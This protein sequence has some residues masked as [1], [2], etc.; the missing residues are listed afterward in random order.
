MS[1][2]RWVLAGGLLCGAGGCQPDAAPVTPPART[3]AV[4]AASL[5][6]AGASAPED[7][8]GAAAAPPRSPAA[9]EA[10]SVPASAAGGAY[11]ETTFDDLK[12]DMEIGAEFD[13][14][15]LTP[16]V[17][18][19]FGQKIRIRG[20]ILPTLRKRGLK[21]FVL[22]RDNMECCF[23]PGAALYDCILVT[24]QDGKTAEF[25]IRPVAVEGV[26]DFEQH[27]PLG[28]TLAI[29]KMTAESVQ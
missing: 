16:Q 10:P 19:L 12:F 8:S 13:R 29:Y 15:L 1:L 21:Q 20:Y 28:P 2:R 26:F 23:G 9:A 4:Q 25:T 17:E 6:G 3:A 27:A 24:M 22:V 5:E 11:R 7:S 14:A 18:S